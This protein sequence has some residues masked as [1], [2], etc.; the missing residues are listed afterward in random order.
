MK[1]KKLY[2]LL[3]SKKIQKSKFT[4][5]KNISS[6][7]AK[8]EF[9]ELYYELIEMKKYISF[10]NKKI[11]D[12]GCGTG[13]FLIFCA[14]IENTLFCIDSDPAEGRGSDENVIQ[15]FRYKIE[16]L[17]IININKIK[18]RIDKDKEK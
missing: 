11:L 16:T 3:Y 13:K 1:L 17:N 7:L 8:K 15:I 2:W 14:L 18:M 9:Y 12:I 6:V 10:E 5:L 4:L